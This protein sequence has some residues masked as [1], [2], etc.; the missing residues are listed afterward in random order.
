MTCFQWA[1]FNN[2]SASVYLAKDNALGQTI[3]NLHKQTFFTFLNAHLQVVILREKSF[4]CKTKHLNIC[5]I[6]FTFFLTWLFQ[7]ANHLETLGLFF[8]QVHVATVEGKRWWG[9]TTL[10]RWLNWP[11][12]FLSTWALLLMSAHY[13][14]CSLWQCQWLCKVN[15]YQYVCIYKHLS[16][17]L[18]QAVA[19][20]RALAVATVVWVR[21][22]L[23]INHYSCTLATAIHQMTQVQSDTH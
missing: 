19:M 18:G 2:Q 10:E 3:C 16:A 6:L 15:F 1:L 22:D 5:T 20:A 9:W 23:S 14:Q 7:S 12:R 17:V 11:D 21:I 13:L 4:V 8:S